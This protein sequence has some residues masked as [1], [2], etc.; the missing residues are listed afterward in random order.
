MYANNNQSPYVGSS[1]YAGNGQQQ[2]QQQQ[3]NLQN[4]YAQQAGASAHASPYASPGGASYQNQNQLQQPQHQVSSRSHVGYVGSG[5]STRRSSRDMNASQH[6]GWGNGGGVEMGSM[7]ANQSPG[8]QGVKGNPGKGGKRDILKE[9]FR[10]T[11]AVGGV[12]VFMGIVCMAGF[13]FVSDGE[14]SAILVLAS[15]LTCISHMFVLLEMVITKSSEAVNIPS[16]ILLAIVYAA[17]L[18]ALCFADQ[19]LPVDSTGDWAYQF[20]EFASLV[21]ALLTIYLAKFQFKNPVM[22]EEDSKPLIPWW[23]AIPVS[24]ALAAIFPCAR[25]RKFMLDWG[26]TFS[27]YLEAFARVPQVMQVA[28]TN[29]NVAPNVG[30]SLVLMFFARIF[31]FWFYWNYSSAYKINKAGT[32]VVFLICS[33]QLGQLFL[34]VDFVYCYV[35]HILR[36]GVR[37][38]SEGIAIHQTV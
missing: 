2:Q 32:M 13:F 5:R 20:F 7:G 1:P 26:W 9:L 31:T 27:T 19:Y 30:H 33:A 22:V 6:Q 38:Q 17:R 8:A 34:L 11:P 15:L 16:N 18:P 37:F 3:N 36:S 23:V 14:L 24:A 12:Y 21:A 35:K 29:T 28:A 10:V 4:P 25:I